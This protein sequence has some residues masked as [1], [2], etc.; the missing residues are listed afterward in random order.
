MKT[1]NKHT[2]LPLAA[3]AS[4]S[5]A[6]AADVARQPNIIMFLVDDMGWQDTSVPFWSDTTALNRRYRTPNMERLAERGVKFTQA[7]ACAVSSPSRASLMSGMNAARHR[8]TNWTL[9]YNRST[10]MEGGELNMPDWNVNGIQPAA[11]ATPHDT[12]RAAVI[13][14]F[15]EL[16]RDAGYRTI[17]CGKAHFGAE[18][19]SAAYPRT[20]GMDVNLGG[21]AFGEAH[22]GKVSV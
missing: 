10:D 20:M 18:G 1:L 3:L 9:H 21:G 11:T 22:A 15:P 13:T 4:I 7:Y 5:Q 12:V 8:V 14:P 16:L 2:F 6:I 19:T 17:H